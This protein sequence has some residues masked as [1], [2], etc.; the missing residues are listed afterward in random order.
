[1]KMFNS[2]LMRISPWKKSSKRRDNGRWCRKI[3]LVYFS[4][5]RNQMKKSRLWSIWESILWLFS[6]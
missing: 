3:V 4:V 5:S 1:M 2:F 6:P